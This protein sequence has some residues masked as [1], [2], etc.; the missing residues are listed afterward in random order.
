MY[1]Y[2]TRVQGNLQNYSFF[3]V[4]S[5][6]R[7]ICCNVNIV[8][9]VYDFIQTVRNSFLN[10]AFFFH[11]KDFNDIHSS[12]NIDEKQIQKKSKNAFRTKQ[13]CKRTDEIQNEIKNTARKTF[14][15]VNLFMNLTIIFSR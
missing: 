14:I 1:I 4:M 11:T 9:E 8:K 12:N 13:F 2:R 7:D 10:D 6:Q 5:V 15:A 3:S